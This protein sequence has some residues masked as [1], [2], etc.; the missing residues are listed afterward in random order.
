M[1]ITYIY[2][3]LFESHIAADTMQPL[4][5]A[6]LAAHTPAE[7]SIRFFDDRLERIDFAEETDLAALSLQTFTA[8]RGYEIA[9][10]FR[11]SGVPVILGGIHPTLLPDEA[12]EHADA[13]V[14]GD[15]ENVWPLVLRDFAQRRLTPRYEGGI[16]SNPVTIRFRRDIFQG[17]RYG[18][19]LPVQLGR[20]CRYDC[21]FCSI[22]SFYRHKLLVRPLRDVLEEIAQI[23]NN[24]LLFVDDNLLL[25]EEFLLRFLREM[26]SM[27]KRWACQI[28]VD[29]AF[30]PRLLQSMQ[31]AGCMAVFIGFE[32]MVRENLREMNKTGNLRYKDYSEATS[33]LR[34][35]GLMICGSFVFGYDEDDESSV[36]NALRFALKNK[37]TLCHFNTLMPFPRTRLYERLERENR[38]HY[39]H[40]WLDSGYR[41]GEMVFHPRK[42]AGHT[43][44][45]LCYDARQEFNSGLNIIGRAFDMKNNA[46]SLSNLFSFLTVN[47]VSHKE[48]RSKQGAK[49]G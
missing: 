15:A 30:N 21:D 27:K 42:I 1:K 9:D 46:R 11:E 48:I 22:H 12:C 23:D 28:S 49:L 44:A 33:R 4:A 47:L 24:F 14:T 45:Q 19:M 8:K 2:P 34:D 10:R 7:W 17:K 26:E 5:V 18:F 16:C 6:A 38:L 41:Y 25:G 40:W 43:L 35:A 37:F 20:G 32:S 3:D 36:A 31:R 13:I 39:R 29:A